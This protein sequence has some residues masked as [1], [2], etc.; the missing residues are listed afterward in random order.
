M[1]EPFG[2]ELFSPLPRSFLCSC[3]YLGD[4]GKAPLWLLASTQ[5][6]IAP[7][8]WLVWLIEARIRTSSRMEITLMMENTDTQT[9][10]SSLT[11]SVWEETLRIIPSKT[12]KEPNPILKVANSKEYRMLPGKC[13]LFRIKIK[14]SRIRS[15]NWS[16]KTN[17]ISNAKWSL[18][19]SFK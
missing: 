14:T 7:S 11:L 5:T 2:L 16:V 8:T 17:H 3:K 1:K 4:P 15:D 19:R 18:L 10:A 6:E 9:S 12:S 13:P